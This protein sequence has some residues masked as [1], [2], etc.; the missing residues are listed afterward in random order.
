MT[1]WLYV[2]ILATLAALGVSLY[3]YEFRFDQLPAVL[4]TH[5]NI[6]GEPDAWTPREHVF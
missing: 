5:W 1:R 3:L 2:A 4:P 6:K